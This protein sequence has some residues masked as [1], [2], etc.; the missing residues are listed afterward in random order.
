MDNSVLQKLLHSHVLF[1][2]DEDK[3]R[4]TY[5]QPQ[6]V[7]G[8]DSFESRRKMP[9]KMMHDHLK[10][11]ANRI[12]QAMKFY[13][14]YAGKDHNL[15][16]DEIKKLTADIEMFLPFQ[17]TFIQME[18][19]AELEYESTGKTSIQKVVQNAYIEDLGWNDDHGQPMYKGNIS[20]YLRDTNKFYFDPNDY[21]FSYREDGDGYTFWVDEE[22][23]FAKYTDTNAEHDGGMYNNP[24]LN[25][26]VNS[27]ISTHFSLILMLTYPQ[28]VNK[29]D[30]LGITPANA[31]KVPFARRYSASELM[32]K[33]KY[34]H[35]VL[36]LDLY[37]AN[38]S[39]NNDSTGESGSRAF[40]AVRKHIRQYSDG[41]ITFVKAHFRGNKDVGLVT[42]DYE[43]VNRSK[44]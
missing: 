42:K 18:A 44:A 20:L 8:S 5:I 36:K 35:K 40:H 9:A 33:P 2:N 41:K 14:P 19:E 37:G 3:W 26:M 7:M 13:L 12:Q 31:S 21:H 11:H 17:S 24:T 29:Q 4:K 16:E 28:I 43:I 22:T 39:K 6:H 25:A 23:P 27:L 34:E 1:Y 30:V 15:S 32:N 38:D 10:S